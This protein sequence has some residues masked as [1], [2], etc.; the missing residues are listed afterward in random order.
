LHDRQIYQRMR[1]RST[2]PRA[3]GERGQ[4]MG[5]AML[6]RSNRLGRLALTTAL[7]SVCSMSP[8]YPH[9]TDAGRRQDVA[10]AVQEGSQ[11]PRRTE[12]GIYGRDLPRGAAAPTSDEIPPIHREFGDLTWGGASSSRE[13]QAHFDQGYR[14]AWAF[15]HGE[16]VRNFRAAQRLDPNC[17]MCLWGEAW[18]LGPNINYPMEPAANARALAVL[19][20]ARRL[21]SGSTAKHRAL[22]DALSKRHPASPGADQAAANAAYADAMDAVQR[23]FPTDAHIAVLT[24]DALM[25]VSPWDYW[26]DGG[27]VA[28]PRTQRIVELLESVLGERRGSRIA[29]MPDHPGAIHLYIHAVEA[30]ERPER[31]AKHAERLPELMPGSGH[32]VHMPSH[33]WYRLGRWRQSL[34]LNQRA[35]A[36]SEALIAGGGQSL[37][38]S[39][40]YYP[41]NVH[42]VMVSAMMG[43]DGR[44]AVEAANKL[45]GIVTERAVR[46]IPW[47]KPIVAAPYLAHARFS[48]PEVVLALPAPAN[49]SAFL[50]AHWHYA[51]GVALARQG[52]ADD[53]LAEAA[54]IQESAGNPEIAELALAG[55][56]APEVLMIAQRVIAGRVAQAAGEPGRAADLFREAVAIQDKL[57]YMEPPFWYMPLRQSLAAALLSAG[58]AQEAV[59]TFRAALKEVPNNGWAAAGL[60]RAA[61]AQGN[62]G[63]AAEARQLISTS[64]F[65][66]ELPALDGL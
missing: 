37:I 7:A 33:I 28:K 32:L 4:K 48:T 55:V 42:F 22:I 24:A 26:T 60:L 17:A 36:A 16:A 52:R 11:A 9:D 57:P 66:G 29:A 30:S 59:E 64:W 56:P 8:A 14:F 43:G 18:A 23:R 2:A 19:E 50:R 44:A 25:N 41:H 53:A 63:A 31:A 47:T 58:R 5:K 61:E 13:A 20:R 62:A 6:K 51:R 45:A 65:G 12:M 21:A 34:E 49:D 54:R 15:N 38:L 10:Q 1:N 27:R 40:A 39:Q 3:P 35:S 46:E